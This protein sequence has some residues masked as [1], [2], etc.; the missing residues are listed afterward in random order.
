MGY[1][2]G[3]TTLIDEIEA[4][5]IKTEKKWQTVGGPDVS[6]GCNDNAAAGWIAT[7]EEFPSGDLTYPRFPG[8]RCDTLRRVAREG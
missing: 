6:D 8:C 1:A 2:H 5:G 7:D 3:E 4:T